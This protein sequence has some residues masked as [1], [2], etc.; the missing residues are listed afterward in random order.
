MDS[1]ALGTLQDPAAI[2]YRAVPVLSQKW[3]NPMADRIKLTEAVVA[4]VAVPNARTILW[5]AAVTGFGLRC[6]PSGVKSFVLVYRPRGLG[7]SGS[8]RTLT[9]GRWP[10]LSVE[11]ARKSA[12]ST[13]GNIADGKDPAKT[14]REIRLQV[15]KTLAT[16][17][18]DYEKHLVRRRVVNI[19]TIMSSLRRGLSKFLN[20]ELKSITR[21][22][23]VAAIDALDSLNKP[24]AADYQRKN[25]RTFAEW[26][27]TRGGA[28]THLAGF[29][30]ERPTRA[31]KLESEK[32]GRALSDV[33]IAKLW[34]ASCQS[35][36]SFGALIRLGLLTGMRRGEMAGLTWEN[37]KLDRIS[38]EATHTKQ[39]RRHEIPLTLPMRDILSSR[40]KGTSTLVFPSEKTGRKMSGWNK[41]VAKVIKASGV[42]FSL[43]DTRRTCRTLMTLTGT[44]TDIAEIAIGHQR[45]ELILL[46]DFSEVWP[47]RTLAFEKVSSH[48]MSA[49]TPASSTFVKLSNTERR[50]A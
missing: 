6:T 21:D 34:Q 5:D 30:R 35:A 4:G 49:V 8:S 17:L 46:Y 45:K 13:I 50:S 27:V 24:G 14:L 47:E 9:L 28:E 26:A 19:K 7:R 10:N 39:G 31:E 1:V 36:H 15:V 32:K 48:I 33:E 29:V 40:Q 11:A 16:A 42:D 44:V 25:A 23:Y 38:L 20:R 22:H 12:R 3:F 37:V 41:L 2:W 43:H 18:E